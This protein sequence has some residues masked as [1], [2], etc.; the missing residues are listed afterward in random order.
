MEKFTIDS[1][2]SLIRFFKAMSHETHDKPAPRG[3]APS[4]QVLLR[5]A[6]KEWNRQAA[7]NKA[8]KNKKRKSDV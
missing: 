2:E 4:Y 8:R 5:Q 1:P 7:I 3:V 6:R